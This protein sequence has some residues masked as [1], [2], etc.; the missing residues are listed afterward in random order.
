MIM[1]FKLLTYNIHKGFS[2]F[3]REFILHDLREKIRESNA[4]FVLLQEVVGE[5]LIHAEKISNWPSEPQ[6]EFLADS[7][8]PHH[9][10]GKNAIYDRRHHG[11]ALL[12]K[13]PIV[14][15]E[16]INISTNRFEQRGLLH[17]TVEIPEVK[18]V[19]HL[20]NVH[21]NLLHSGRKIQIQHILKRLEAH[22]DSSHP[23][24]IGGDFNDWGVRLTS[25]FSNAGLSEAFLSANGDHARS[26]PN[27]M[28]TL[29][30]DRVYFKN[31]D[32]KSARSLSGSPWSKLSD[33]I[34]LEVEF[35]LK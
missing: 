4:D 28:P 24:L 21:L 32:I 12:S 15:K 16:N 8:W 3:N 18:K 7:I 35:K 27:F 13:Y 2:L 23:V 1:N 34:P 22:V 6:L 25:Y 33:H 19:I 10:Y 11:N 9:H 5:N 29:K 17:A 31:L 14:A 26:F 20:F 30:L